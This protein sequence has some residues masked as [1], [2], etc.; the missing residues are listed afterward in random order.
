MNRY[1]FILM[2][3]LLLIARPSLADEA[4]V[5]LYQIDKNTSNTR[6]GRVTFI[7]TQ[8]GLLIRPF[9]KG[10]SPG[11]HGLHVHQHPDCGDMGNHAGGHYDPTNTNRHQGPFGAGHL[12]DLPLLYVDNQGEANIP[13][14][15]P[16][17]RVSDLKGLTL[18]VHQ[19]GDTYLDT[20]PLGGGGLR[21]AC[22]IINLSV[23]VKK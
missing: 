15:A 5:E 17:L 8:Y 16:R 18:I 20:P 7:D 12:G 2:T 13:I 22:G 9:L 14:L 6:L 1:A 3:L 23:T 10:L 4:F 11:M 21:L 19:N